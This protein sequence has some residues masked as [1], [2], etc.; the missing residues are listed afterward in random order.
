M[1]NYLLQKTY[2]E[3]YQE[4]NHNYLVVAP[5][6]FLKLERW[7][8]LMITALKPI[9]RKHSCHILLDFSALEV[10]SE[11]AHQYL[12]SEVFPA[13]VKAGLKRI[14]VVES[15]DFLAKETSEKVCA[16]VMSTANTQKLSL[17]FKLFANN[18]AAST[19]LLQPNSTKTLAA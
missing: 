1:R 8:E 3:I 5:Q 14:A 4:K 11:D 16:E 7:K 18:Q 6:G 17:E 2:G 19:W 12:T 13:L 10:I 15:T 9:S